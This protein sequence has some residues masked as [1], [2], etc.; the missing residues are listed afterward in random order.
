MSRST[1][2]ISSNARHLAHA[3]MDV[4]DADGVVDDEL[5]EAWMARLDEV[6]GDI[7]VKMQALRAVR[8]RLLGEGDTLK[9]EGKRVQTIAK[10]RSSDAERVRGYM[11]ELLLAHRELNPGVDKIETDDGFVRLN[12]MTS[13]EVTITNF[14]KVSEDYLTR[15]APKINKS[16]IVSAHKDGLEVEGVTVTKVVNEHVMEGGE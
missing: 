3:L 15:P 1:F 6:C 2:D 16:A 12:K 10:R 7:K 5:Y 4:T 8:A 14:D 13:Y 9:T 11:K